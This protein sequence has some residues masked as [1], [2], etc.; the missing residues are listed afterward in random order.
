M[1]S[2]LQSFLLNEMVQ[3]LSLQNPSSSKLEEYTL[4]CQRADVIASL[5]HAI[6]FDYSRQQLKAIAKEKLNLPLGLRIAFSEML[7][8]YSGV[9]KLRRRHI[10]TSSALSGSPPLLLTW[11]LQDTDPAY[12]HSILNGTALSKLSSDGKKRYSSSIR[13]TF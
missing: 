13:L 6:D 10:A 2:N 5:Q 4:A 11:N 1:A 3:I 9:L 7:Q 8:N 12:Q